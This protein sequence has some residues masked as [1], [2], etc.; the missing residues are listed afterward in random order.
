[1]QPQPD[2]YGSFTFP[3]P[4]DY[5]AQQQSHVQQP[6]IPVYTPAFAIA[7]YPTPQP[8][9][10]APT[11]PAAYYYQAQPP[12]AQ[13]QQYIA[14]AAPAFAVPSPALSSASTS[15]SR[16]SSA[17]EESPFTP[18]QLVDQQATAHLPLYSYTSDM[19]DYYTQYCEAIRDLGRFK[20]DELKSVI[21]KFNTSLALG[22][23]TTGLKA[24]LHE[25]LRSAVETLYYL[26]DKT[27]FVLAKRL[28]G[29][30][31]NGASTTTT[32]YG[33]AT[34]GYG[35]STSAGG[36]GAYS[37]PTGAYGMSAP[38][39][40]NAGYG[41][42]AAASTS[43]AGALPA[44]RFGGYN[45]AVGATSSASTSASGAGANWQT[46]QLNEPPIKFRP[47]PFYRVEKSLAGVTQLQKAA[48]GD[49]KVAVCTFALTE[50][51]RGLLTKARESPSNPQYQ[52]RLY[53]TSDTN[54][55]LSRPA[56]NQFPAPIEFPPTAEIKLN[57]VVVPA[58]VKGI[59]KQPGTTPPVNLSAKTGP[60]V[61]PSQA[62]VQK[63]EIAYVQ[64]ERVYYL[65][66]YLIEY[67]PIEKVVA[68]VKAG[69]T[70]SKE[71]VIQNIIDL[72]SDD[73]I[74][75]TALGM[76]LK[77]PLS[78]CRIN[79]PI[80]SV[81]CGHIACFDAETW[82][83][84]NEQTPTWGC[85]I[86]SK[87]LKVDDMIVDGY[88][89]DILRICSD[90]VD[91]VT[92]EP[93]GTWRSD[94]DKH[95]TAKPKSVSAA[96]SGRN[97]PLAP[98]AANGGGLGLP[99]DDKGKARASPQPAAAVLTLDSDSDSDGDEPL[100]KRPRLNGGYNPSASVSANGSVAPPSGT[101]PAGGKKGEVL[102]LT[103][104]SDDEDGPVRAPP[105]RPSLA[106]A[107]VG[108]SESGAE[109]K[110]VVE[111]QRDI[112]AM[113][114]RMEE[115]YGPNWRQSFGYTT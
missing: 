48:Q 6:Y 73:E 25:R 49:R 5:P 1:M 87:Q 55:N 35:A 59:K 70:R 114:K 63:V 53:C 62:G 84:M 79:I 42:S 92:V 43:R 50:G 16:P 103:L 74:E 93:D 41:A 90:N 89:E 102:D 65:V 91:S 100:A 31:R 32:N 105:A 30:V 107:K 8:V 97:T 64:T 113:N 27:K 14:P 108:S 69:K 11:D 88:F 44:P 86:C 10:Y 18:Q 61:N 28:I 17:R 4:S 110:S 9:F 111:V 47:S 58:N 13:P 112:D 75:A 52:L 96:A 106:M 39:Y 101:G 46:A 40:T 29:D 20:V 34:T 67:T 80:R 57:G 99:A 51:Q 26:S 60:A 115:Q 12:P 104:S 66:A 3:N 83:E 2:P 15:T 77:D 76:S 68:R 82:F 21:R 109:R 36:A 19:S 56:A 94:D 33:Y 72:N 85:P 37:S 95:G 23:S 98:A 54:W 78:F 24:V 7:P 38:S 22:L 71:E 45:A 81:H